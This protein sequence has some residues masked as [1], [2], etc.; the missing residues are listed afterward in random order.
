[1]RPVAGGVRRRAPRP[2]LVADPAMEPL[3]Q[4]SGGRRG[5]A[6]LARMPVRL[7][8]LRRDP[9]SRPQAAAQAGRERPRRARRALRPRVPGGVPDRRQ[10]HG[11]PPPGEGGGRRAPPLERAA[12]PRAGVLHHPGFDRRREGRGAARAVRRGRSHLRVHRDRDPERGRA[13]GGQQAPEPAGRPRRPDREVSRPRDHGAERHDGRLRR[14]RPGRVRAA[15]RVR[16]GHP[17][18]QL[19]RRGAGGAGGDPPSCPDAPE[20]TADRGRQRDGDHAVG[21]ERR[22]GRHDRRAFGRRHE[23]AGQPAVPPESSSASG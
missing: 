14:G 9:L 16:H 7:R 5:G 20:R 11:V 4:P 23:V 17:G 2:R 13:A 6:D 18:P 21:D 12:G 15:V 8:V 10:L 3:P 22:A 1:M 19:F